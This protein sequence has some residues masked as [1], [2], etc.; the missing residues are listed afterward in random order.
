MIRSRTITKNFDK[1]EP[2]KIGSNVIVANVN[3]DPTFP[4][5]VTKRDGKVVGFKREILLKHSEESLLVIVSFDELDEEHDF[6]FEE[7][8]LKLF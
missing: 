5:K 6:W 7:I 3:R 8:Q 2:I 4:K 1:L